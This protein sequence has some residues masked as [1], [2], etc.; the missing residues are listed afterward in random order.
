MR[1]FYI[2]M[3]LL[4]ISSAVIRITGVSRP[5]TPGK[6]AP[7]QQVGTGN[8]EG[9]AARVLVFHREGSGVNPCEDL[10]IA[11]SGNAV[12]GNCGNG[13]EKQYAL[14]EEERVQLQ[15]WLEKLKAVNYEHKDETSASGVKI[16]LYL[17]GRGNRQASDSEIQQLVAFADGLAA[18]IIAQS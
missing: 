15:T 13:M 6:E 12:F 4:I 3:L 16:Q 7:T 18:K 1:I 14:N 2:L 10:V 17:N 9:L 11:A 5:I 8:G